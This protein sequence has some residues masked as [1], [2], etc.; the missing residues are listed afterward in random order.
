MFSSDNNIETISQLVIELKKYVELQKRSLQ[1]DFIDKLSKLMAAIVMGAVIFLI[2]VIA[3][4]F[5]SMALSDAIAPFVG[6]TTYGNAIIFCIYALIG[7]LVYV[8]R[9]TWIEAPIVNF[10]GNLFLNDCNNSNN[11][12]REHSGRNA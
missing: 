7:L 9:K 10:L 12:N 3:L 1:I 8:N 6:G 2:G 5:A 11:T 4:V